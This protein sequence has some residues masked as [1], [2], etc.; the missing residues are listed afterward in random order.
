[1]AISNGDTVTIEYTGR[2]DDGTVF[3]TSL[4]SVATEE[5]L[6][7]GL[8]VREPFL[9]RDRFGRRVEDGAVVESAG[10]LDGDGVAVG[11][12]HT[13]RTGGSLISVRSGGCEPGEPRAASGVRLVEGP[14][15]VVAR[16]ED[17]VELVVGDGHVDCGH[18]FV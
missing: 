2:L 6:A 15:L 18:V 3:D 16:L 11:N 1:M 7:V 5:G 17:P 4:E 10:V 9:G 14:V 8:V 13:A 12:S